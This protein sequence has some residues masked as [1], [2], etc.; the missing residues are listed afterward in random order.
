M[1]SM[2]SRPDCHPLDLV[3]VCKLLKGRHSRWTFCWQSLVRIICNSLEFVRR[4]TVS[5][6]YQVRSAHFI[7]G[8]DGGYNLAE[9]VRYIFG[10]GNEEPVPHTW[11]ADKEWGLWHKNCCSY[12][13]RIEL[14]LG[15]E[16]L[17]GTI[18]HSL[19]NYVVLTDTT[20][21]NARYITFGDDP[22]CPSRQLYYAN[23]LSNRILM[24]LSV[25]S[26]CNSR[27]YI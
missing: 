7:S 27:I 5:A 10:C 2:L 23:I 8:W 20:T 22:L 11:D 25:H 14:T 26:Y 3:L 18:S 15:D 4:I 19:T 17:V 16:W 9:S 24:Y 6:R 1:V 13:N 12:R 21:G